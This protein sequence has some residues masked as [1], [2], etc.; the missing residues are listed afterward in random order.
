M[1]WV[2]LC[3]AAAGGLATAAERPLIFPEPQ[4]MTVREGRLSIDEGVPVLVRTAPRRAISRSLV[5]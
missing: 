1:R 5:N 4:K 2:L 3:I